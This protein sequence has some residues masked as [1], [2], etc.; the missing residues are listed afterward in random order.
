M[1][2]VQCT[3]DNLELN[4]RW[5]EDN[6]LHQFAGWGNATMAM[7]DAVELIQEQE[8]KIASLSNEAEPVKPIYDPD[9]GRL[10]PRCGAC[11]SRIHVE[12]IT[13]HHPSFCGECGRRIDW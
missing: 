9:V 3:L 4:I 10:F 2:D 6:P 13:L 8:L 5:I 1:V 7:R 11:G 12:G